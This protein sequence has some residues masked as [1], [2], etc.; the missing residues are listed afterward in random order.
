MNA[1]TKARLI[2]RVRTLGGLTNDE[3]SA[4][5]ELL[6]T[7]KAYGLV[8]ENKREDIEERLRDELPVLVEDETKRIISDSPDAPNHV[9]IE[10]DNLEALTT[11]A[12]THAGKIDVIYIDPPYNTGAKNWKYNNNFVDNEDDFRHSKWLSWIKRRL[13][14]ARKLL[15]DTGII[16]VTID[17]YEF[18]QLKLVMDDVFR[19]HNYLATVVI[20]NNPSG[21][22][23]V[24]GFSINHEYALF[25]SKSGKSSVGYLS[26]N[27]EQKSRYSEK[28][29]NGYFEWENFRKNGTD[30][31]RKDRPKQFFPIIINTSDNSL[32]I[33]DLNWDDVKK[34]YLYAQIFN[35]NEFLLLPLTPDGNEKV[36]K[37]GLERTRQILDQILV[38][39]KNG[40]YE[41]YRKKYLN[42]SGSL[43]RTW[44]DKPEYSARDSGTRE[45]SN[46]F[47]PTK[48]FDFPKA[49]EAV[50]DCLRAANLR[51][52]NIIL[53]FFAGS[54]TTLHAVM[55]LNAEDG[56]QR[57]CILVTNN[58]N[59]I[60]ENVT[61]E[62]NKRV[63]NGYTKPNGD[64]VEGLHANNLRYY[65]TAYVG[66]NRTPQNLRRL[67]ELSTDMLC[68]KEDLYTEC[69]KF[70]G[71][72]TR[73]QFFRYYEQDSKR[74]LIIYREEYVPD[75]VNL[76]NRLDL[77]DG[78][79]I[80]V[81]VF[82]PSEDPWAGEFELVEDKII[83]CA[84]PMAILNAYRRVLPKRREQVIYVDQETSKKPEV[85]ATEPTLFD[86]NE[87]GG[88][89]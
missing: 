14:I 25:Y 16:V 49:P 54:G 69:R 46:I 84:L 30:S 35:S 58:E 59:G 34:E 67:I 36:W 38:K 6:R 65:R 7:E 66:R 41:L 29:D 86:M 88:A 15:R 19:P 23:T 4:L 8:W 28:D 87:E 31:D 17:D 75:L 32:R 3:R 21:R 26:H 73:K 77:P 12:Y 55:Q 89:Q 76:I 56:G 37:Y 39:I 11:L 18:A 10:G 40:R 57:Q 70:A 78:E 44:W 62:R 74:M 9:L 48:V 79:R 53:D 60:C 51:S 5:L 24:R 50:K 72:K 2:E 64:H 85:P 68:I 45:L 43:P 42:T 47:G 61:Y 22:S 83:L 13:V 1:E 20:K 71:V 82:S 27:E 63:I 33:P 81:Y 52:D 80:K